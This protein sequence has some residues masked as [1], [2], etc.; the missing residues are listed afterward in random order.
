M[1][2]VEG[3]DS[4]RTRAGRCRLR[5]TE[6]RVGPDLF[7]LPGFGPLAAPLWISRPLFDIKSGASSFLSALAVHTL[8]PSG[9]VDNRGL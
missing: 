4:A 7:P 6:S 2:V 5:T 9:V 8:G 3:I 1:F